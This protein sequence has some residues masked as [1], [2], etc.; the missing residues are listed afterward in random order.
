MT[1]GQRIR[2]RREALGLS[3]EKVAEQMGVSRQ[4]VGK[5][6]SDDARPSTENLLRLAQLLGTD[7]QDLATGEAAPP[8][9]KKVPLARRRPGPGRAVPGAGPASPAPRPE[10]PAFGGPG[11][12][13]FRRPAG[14]GGRD[15]SPVP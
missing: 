11:Q 5:W 13:L 9:Q 8:P 10:Q 1:L 4:A 7:V 3:Q 12:L 15:R 6:E 2:E 14:D